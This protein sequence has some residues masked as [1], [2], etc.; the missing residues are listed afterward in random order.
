MPTNRS[1]R[2]GPTS[3][4]VGNLRPKASVAGQM[5]AGIGDCGWP[6]GSAPCTNTAAPQEQAPSAEM[7]ETSNDFIGSRIVAMLET[8]KPK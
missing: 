8:E 5:E 6:A 2:G 7:M 4:V 3:V 1:G